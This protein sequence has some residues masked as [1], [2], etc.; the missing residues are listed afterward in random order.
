MMESSRIKAVAD[1]IVEATARLPSARV[2]RDLMTEYVSQASQDKR[3]V[4]LADV[5]SCLVQDLGSHVPTPAREEDAWADLPSTGTLLPDD[6]YPRTE[7]RTKSLSQHTN[8]CSFCG[9]LREFYPGGK[10]AS[11][12]ESTIAE[13]LAREHGVNRI[14]NGNER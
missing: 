10:A 1:E 9:L 13:H 12:T 2:I 4:I 8:A 5:Y 7:S 6:G 3:I 14:R 11:D